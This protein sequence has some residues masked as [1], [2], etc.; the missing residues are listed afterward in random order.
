MKKL[1]IVSVVFLLLSSCSNSTTN[2]EAKSDNT[3]SGGLTNPT[4]VDTL[5]HPSGIDNSSVI[6]TDTAAMNVQN[7][8]KKAD[9]AA[10]Q[11]NK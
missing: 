11:K 1:C 6:S 10:K 2:D 5:K 8:Y 4:A 7:S 9:S 3:D